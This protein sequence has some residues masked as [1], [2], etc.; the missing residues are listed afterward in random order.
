VLDEESVDV[1]SRD[2]GA[3]HAA[4]RFP[5]RARMI[6]LSQKQAGY[7]SWLRPFNFCHGHRADLAAQACAGQKRRM[8]WIKLAI[9][10]VAAALT[11]PCITE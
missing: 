4:S 8:A 7:R 2:C 1:D 9:I 3:A 5:L 6:F 11:S 10:D